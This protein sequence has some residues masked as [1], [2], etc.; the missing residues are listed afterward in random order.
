MA[1]KLDCELYDDRAPDVYHD[2]VFVVNSMGAFSS[3]EFRHLLADQVRHCKR[4]IYVQQDYTI[5]PTSQVQKVLRDERGESH[6]FPFEKGPV[7]WTTVPSL[8]CKPQD[9]YVNWNALTYEESFDYVGFRTPGLVYWGSYRKGREKYFGE[10]FDDV[11]YQVT[12]LV[13]KPI[14]KKFDAL[15]AVRQ[16]PWKSISQLAHYEATVYI[17][18]EK[19]HGEFHSLANRFYEALSAGLAI[20]IDK[21]AVSTF[22]EEGL[23]VDPYWVVSSAQDVAHRLPA[24]RQTAARQKAAWSDQFREQLDKDVEEALK[25]L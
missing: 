23:Y 15:N 16:D 21:N 5:H 6:M 10:Y 22:D 4:M 3:N 24:A 1:D 12:L 18:D 19:Q 14:F 20:F 9:S 17:E 11:N 8:M 25:R 7:L 2:D 13:G